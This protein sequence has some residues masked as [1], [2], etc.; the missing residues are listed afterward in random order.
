MEGDDVYW[1][2]GLPEPPELPS[3][4]P[5]TTDILIVGAGYAGLSAAIAAADGGAQVPSEL[6]I[7]R[8]V[9]ALK[10]PGREW[11]RR[12]VGHGR[13]HNIATGRR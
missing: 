5:E 10:R 6:T 8:P 11:E 12:C 4:P 13:V 9:A 2:E 7:Q 1:W 3:D